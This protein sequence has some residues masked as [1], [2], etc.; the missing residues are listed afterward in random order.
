MKVISVDAKHRFFPYEIS[1]ER[2][3]K[4]SSVNFELLVLQNMFREQS[5]VG[6]SPNLVAPV[7]G[8][9]ND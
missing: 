9:V 3:T 1:G 6:G 8:K 7:V 2:T 4:E 5:T